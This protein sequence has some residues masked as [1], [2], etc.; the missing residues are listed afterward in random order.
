[1]GRGILRIVEHFTFYDGP[2]RQHFV[3]LIFETASYSPSNVAC[4]NLFHGGGVGK[5][6]TIGFAGLIQSG[7]ASNP[8]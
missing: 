1:M 8:T 3:R 6:G 4:V 7:A 5:T 2:T